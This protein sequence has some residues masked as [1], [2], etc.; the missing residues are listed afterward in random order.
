MLI[1]RDWAI[2]AIADA[3]ER[4]ERLVTLRGPGGIGKTAVAH[5][6]ARRW[7]QENES[8]PVFCELVDVERGNDLSA[9]IATA[10][11]VTLSEEADDPILRGADAPYTLLVLDDLRPSLCDVVHGWIDTHESLFVLVTSRD[12]LPTPRSF[13]IILP[14]LTA[15]PVGW[16]PDAPM[17][18]ALSLLLR[19]MRAAGYRGEPSTREWT[20]LATVA[21]ALEGV[22][23]AIE[24]F[25][26]RAAYL[27]PMELQSLLP[28]MLDVAALHNVTWPHQTTLRQTIRRS[29]DGLRDD[30]RTALTCLSTF[31]GAFD[32]DAASSVL[33]PAGATPLAVVDLLQAL[34]DVSLL[35]VEPDE[36]ARFRLFHSVRAFV[37]DEGDAGATAEAQLRHRDLFVRRARDLLGEMGGERFG[38]ASAA[39]ARQ[40]DDFDAVLERGVHHGDPAWCTAAIEVLIALAEM[41]RVT[42]GASDETLGRLRDTV[43]HLESRIDPG[44]RAQAWLTVGRLA[45]H[46][47]ATEASVED[48][49]RALATASGPAR[50]RALVCSALALADLGRFEEA[51]GRVQDGDATTDEDGSLRALRL[52]AKGQVL[53]LA[54]RLAEA[55]V[56]MEE[57][58]SVESN[59]GSLEDQLWRRILHAGVLCDLGEPDRAERILLPAIAQARAAGLQRLAA[60]GDSMLAIACLATGALVRA[61]ALFEDTRDEHLR[62]GAATW[63]RSASVGLGLVQL[64][65]AHIDD[66][67][68]TFLKLVSPP[69]KNRVY[70]S[71]AYSALAVIAALRG[72]RAAATEALAWSRATPAAKR[73]EIQLRDILLFVAGRLLG[74]I[75]RDLQ[76]ATS[77]THGPYGALV[78]RALATIG[79][80]PAMPA[81]EEWL[82]HP[83]ARWF[84]APGATEVVSC[85]RREAARRILH[86]LIVLHQTNPGAAL[87]PPEA[88]AVGW[89]NEKMTRSAAKNRLHVTIALL[90]KLGLRPLLRATNE[91]YVLDPSAR[92]RLAGAA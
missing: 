49:S 1:G 33:G 52:G 91:G 16:S 66:A 11:G 65:T 86:A 35:Q 21:R 74:D 4:G 90:R 38:E 23:L 51:L 89:P 92:I 40:I 87:S 29:W 83:D 61:R 14:P 12:R 44:L 8:T 62:A 26:A 24:I 39:M 37:L 22:P 85:E 77:V 73:L 34:H 32:T 42:S 3:L 64:A 36:R 58:A 68:E 45:L 78:V 27:S 41:K 43:S 70:T 18:D 80:E 56:A 50:I 79:G 19:R 75:P 63:A 59:S 46:G 17:P 55:N 10:L 69:G 84:R 60:T 2:D 9:R 28:Q 15:P 7:A 54:S 48:L 76:P 20:D 47:G 6:Y 67:H 31:R 57:A 72:D 25:A 82:V 53:A 88:L 13:D 30:V 71:G 5:A 81:A